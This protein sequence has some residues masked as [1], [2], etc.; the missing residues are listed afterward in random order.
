MIKNI[1]CENFPFRLR[2]GTQPSSFLY[3]ALFKIARLKNSPISIVLKSA[4]ATGGTQTFDVIG[5]S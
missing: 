4:P 5:G 1:P 2:W 3:P